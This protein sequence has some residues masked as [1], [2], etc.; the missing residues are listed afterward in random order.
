M[1]TRNPMQLKALLNNYAVK[2]RLIPQIVL[3]NYLLQR[4]LERL[5]LSAYRPNFVVKGGIVISFL[6]G[7]DH[8][9]TM[10][11]DA[12][13]LGINAS[14]ELLAKAIRDICAIEVDDGIAFRFISLS[15]IAKH[16]GYPG[17]RAEIETV[18]GRMRTLLTIDITT[19][20]K[21]TP[22]PVESELPL[23]FEERKIRVFSYTVETIAAEKLHTVLSRATLNTRPRDFYDLHLIATDPHIV[24]RPD[25][26]ARA[27]AGTFAMRNSSELL[28]GCGEILDE[29]A[30]S[31]TMRQRWN[32]YQLKFDYA[33][34]IAFDE[35]IAAVK[36]L[37]IVAQK[38]DALD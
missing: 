1:T 15:A 9:T 35:T 22:A 3:Q 27:I 34:G 28:D 13:V 25:V 12:T 10:D 14:R 17:F 32:A 8:R 19:G 29:V 6:Y 5:S 26:L 31:S 37:L 11:V 36:T 38:T 18:Y 20:D 33:R 21:I 30:A 23:L 16:N 24:F 7:L 4:L 2:H